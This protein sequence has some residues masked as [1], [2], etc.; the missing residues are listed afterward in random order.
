M[1]QAYQIAYIGA[2]AT[3]FSALI[4]AF[5]PI[6]CSRLKGR[7]LAIFAVSF[8]ALFVILTAILVKPAGIGVDDATSSTNYGMWSDWSTIRVDASDTC[9]VQTRESNVY[10]M[11]VYVTQE[12]ATNYPRS[13]RDYSIGGAYEAYG[14]RSSYGEKHFEVTVTQEQLNAAVVYAPN[15]FIPNNDDLFVGGYNRSSQEAYVM[16]IPIDSQGRYYPLFIK[17]KETITEY[18]YRDIIK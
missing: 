2:A 5:V 4:M 10:R 16:Q 18:R 3:I 14:C 12:N 6:I 17:N 7:K 13:F 8:I 15:T 11:C 1:D 9:E